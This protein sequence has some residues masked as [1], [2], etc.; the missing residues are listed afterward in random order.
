MPGKTPIPPPQYPGQ[1]PRAINLLLPV[2]TLIAV[3]FAALIITGNGNLMNGSGMKALI[4]AVVVALLVAS[5]LCV[6]EKVFTPTQVIDEIFKGH[7]RHAAGSRSFCY[8]VS[9]WVM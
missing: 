8:L 4:W 7:E 9:P 6:V 5:V 1:K 2:G 3:M